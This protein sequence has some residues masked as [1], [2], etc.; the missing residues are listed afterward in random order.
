LRSNEQALT[1]KFTKQRVRAY[2]VNYDV[3]TNVLGTKEA[4]NMQGQ[5]SL[6]KSSFKQE[7]SG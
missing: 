1:N 6:K 7:T 2:E 5:K 3:Q 4:T